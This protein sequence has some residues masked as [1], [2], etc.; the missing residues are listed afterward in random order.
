MGL[1]GAERR[2][3]SGTA[4]NRGKSGAGGRREGGNIQ[5]A[6]THTFYRRAGSESGIDQEG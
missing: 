5:D 2:P 4:H 1:S 3:E 6:D